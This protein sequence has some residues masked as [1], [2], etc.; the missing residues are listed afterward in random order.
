MLHEKLVVGAP[1]SALFG[2]F[3]SGQSKLV[4]RRSRSAQIASRSPRGESVKPP[5]SV[6]NRVTCSGAPPGSATRHSCSLPDALLR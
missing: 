4:Q 3:T 6:A 5:M 1:A 2:G